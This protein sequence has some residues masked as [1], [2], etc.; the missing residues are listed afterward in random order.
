M[1]IQGLSYLTHLNVSYSTLKGNALL[2]I[3]SLRGL[4]ELDVSGI[5]K[6]GRNR[7]E[8]LLSIVSDL[9]TLIMK[10][11]PDVYP[12]HVQEL[13]RLFPHVKRIQ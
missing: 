2:D 13:D 6:F 7:P 4:V 8:Y 1:L 11:C 9:D 3:K 10:D 5:F 12:E